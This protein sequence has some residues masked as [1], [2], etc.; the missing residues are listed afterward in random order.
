MGERGFALKKDINKAAWESDNF[1]LLCETCLGENAYVRMMKDLHGAACKI[2]ERPYTVF[3]WKP[4]K[5]SRY[6]RTEIC[7]T[8]ARMKN[9][10]QTCILDL[11]YG[12][13]VQ[14]RDAFLSAEERQPTV[15]SDVNREWAVQQH[16]LAI[17]NGDTEGAGKAPPNQSLLRLARSEPY[18]QRN[19]AHLC[20]FFAKGECTRGNECPYLHELPNAR[21]K[22]KSTNIKNRFHGQKDAVAK[23]MLASAS[24]TGNGDDRDTVHTTSEEKHDD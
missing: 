5:R 10:C 18:Y 14:V 6:K 23:D 15:Q 17:E 3:R 9:V 22:K 4:G 11:Q 16:Q 13:P 8:C 19:K 20:S 12:L 7:Q 21:S 1:P 2:C 24:S